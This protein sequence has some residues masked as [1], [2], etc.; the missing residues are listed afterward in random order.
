M[1]EKSS[2]SHAIFSVTL[3]QEK[4]VPSNGQSSHG[5]SLQRSPS[6]SVSGNKASG[7]RRPESS[8]GFRPSDNGEEGEW[9]I[10]HSKF[11][12]VDLAGSERVSRCFIYT[13]HCRSIT[14][15][16]KLIIIYCY[17]AQANCCRRRQTKGGNQY[18]RWFVSIRKCHFR[19]RRSL[20]EEY[21]CT[22]S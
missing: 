1:N 11:H 4:W 17:I 18:Q 21:T 12:F 5:I 7:L 15:S 19:P 10:T 6:P 20:K 16:C 8:I 14:H 22:L 3:R 13:E 9:V 2:R